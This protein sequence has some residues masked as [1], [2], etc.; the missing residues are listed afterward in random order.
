MAGMTMAARASFPSMLRLPMNA[1]PD[2]ALF[3]SYFDMLP[4]KCNNGQGLD[5][6]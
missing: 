2:Y 1:V 5:D 6:R 3:V 4:A